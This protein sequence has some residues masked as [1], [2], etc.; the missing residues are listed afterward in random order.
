MTSGTT[1]TATRQRRTFGG[2]TGLLGSLAVAGL[3]LGSLVSGLGFAAACN[4]R[5]DTF[6]T[7]AAAQ[8]ELKPNGVAPAAQPAGPTTAPAD[9]FAWL[10]EIPRQAGYL[11]LTSL[12]QFKRNDAIVYPAHVW[13][14]RAVDAAH[15]QA[16]AVRQQWLKAGI[17]A[18]GSEQV[19][20]VARA[21]EGTMQSAADRALVQ[22][23]VRA[24]AE[25]ESWSAGIGRL[26]DRIAP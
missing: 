19:D 21:L 24:T 6:P 7:L 1:G 2:K 12:L 18:D 11:L 20:E 13:L 4:G 17:H 5:L 23:A 3:L 16:D 22:A 9:Q 26:R 25:R 14:A 8:R 10:G 15:C